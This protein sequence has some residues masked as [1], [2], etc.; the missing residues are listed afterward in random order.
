MGDVFIIDKEKIDS[1]IM[2]LEHFKNV[3]IY[4]GYFQA[5][6]SINCIFRW[7]DKSSA[8]Q[9]IRSKIMISKNLLFVFKLK[10]GLIFGGYSP[11]RIQNC[12]INPEGS[13][14]FRL[15]P[16]KSKQFKSR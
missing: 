8:D 13:F 3:A 2:R 5:F 12:K 11:N 1:Q 4:G 14:L 10:S 6:K 15:E 16:C 9:G 7:P